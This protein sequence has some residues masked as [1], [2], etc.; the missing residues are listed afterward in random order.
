M[1]VT[2]ITLA[3]DV[4]H[5]HQYH[6]AMGRWE[7]NARGRLERSALELFDERGYD[8]TTTAEIAHRA[9]LTERTFF[10]HFADK[11]EVLFG[12]AGAFQQ[13]LVAGVAGAPDGIAPIDAVAAG[14]QEIA[15]ILQED[16]PHA[17]ARQ[18]VIAANP[19]LQE[20]ELI[21]LAALAAAIGATLRARGVTEPSASLTAE[22]GIGA[23]KVAFEQWV[24]PANRRALSA[25]I[26][27]SLEQLKA[28]G[29]QR[30]G[31]PVTRS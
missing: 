19:E 15:T 22:A 30:A 18:A 12:G 3:P 27:E 1:T 16:R 14:L 29:A 6:L 8:Q 23:F 2:V 11:R 10:R 26:A 9:G 20:R 31:T 21:K 7:P 17:I 24:D 4:S 5:W 25:V 28:L 13:L